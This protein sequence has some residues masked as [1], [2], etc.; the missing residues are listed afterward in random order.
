MLTLITLINVQRSLCL[1]IICRWIYIR[2]GQERRRRREEYPWNSDAAKKSEI[3]DQNRKAN[4]ETPYSIKLKSN[5]ISTYSHRYAWHS[6][7]RSPLDFSYPSNTTPYLDES[8][9]LWPKA[10]SCVSQIDTSSSNQ[11][12]RSKIHT[13]ASLISAREQ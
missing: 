2:D 13:T 1:L 11:K 10:K 6:R 7:R 4:A 3:F 8:L 5:L 9:I 12:Q